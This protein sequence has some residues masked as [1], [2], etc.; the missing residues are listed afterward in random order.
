MFPPVLLFSEVECQHTEGR[1]AHL[2][3]NKRFL[4]GMLS[5]HL[6]GQRPDCTPLPPPQCCCCCRGGDRLYGRGHEGRRNKGEEYFKIKCI[7]TKGTAHSYKPEQ[8]CQP[9]SVNEKR[10]PPA[11]LYWDQTGQTEDII[12]GNS[13]ASY[14]WRNNYYGCNVQND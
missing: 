8:A 14:L 6:S 2:S 9:I 5:L 7:W 11:S 3:T 10:P 13:A 1:R 4:F 12:R